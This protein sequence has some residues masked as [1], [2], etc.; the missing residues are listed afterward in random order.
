MFRSLPLAVLKLLFPIR[1]IDPIQFSEQ[2]R[3]GERR[4]LAHGNGAHLRSHAID[5]V[6]R[7]L[8][9]LACARLRQNLNLAGT[10]QQ[11][12]S[13]ESLGSRASQIGRASCRERVWISGGGVEVNDKV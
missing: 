5:D 7:D 12:H 9:Q 8:R 11:K 6:V 10:L 1:W 3:P 13:Q 4:A 2:T